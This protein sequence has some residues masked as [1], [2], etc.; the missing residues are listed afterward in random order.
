LLCSPK[1]GLWAAG[2]E[3]HASWHQLYW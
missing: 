1:A 3:E 2:S